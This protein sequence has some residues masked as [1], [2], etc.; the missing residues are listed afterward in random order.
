MPVKIAGFAAQS[1]IEQRDRADSTPGPATRHP[2]VKAGDG[3]REERNVAGPVDQFSQR[4]LIAREREETM[5]FL[6][7]V[8]EGSDAAGGW[9]AH[10]SGVRICEYVLVS[11]QREDNGCSGIGGNRD[12]GETCIG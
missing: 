11:A 10:F 3:E 8:K 5:P 6:H 1:R 12:G 9:R 2:E 4:A 7:R